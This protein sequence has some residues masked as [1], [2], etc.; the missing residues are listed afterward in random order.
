MK[1]SVVLSLSALVATGC[2]S[3]P[4]RIQPAYVSPLEYS[5]LS[6]EQR[7]EEGAR[8]AERW[9]YLNTKLTHRRDRDVAAVGGALNVAGGA[10]FLMRGKDPALEAEYAQIQGRLVALEDAGKHGC[11]F[12]SPPEREPIIQQS[13]EK[14]W[15]DSADGQPP[16]R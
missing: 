6:C 13:Q 7:N 12:D 4:H 15:L 11:R 8:L 5:A 9:A 3:S 14:P 10:V 2:A 16:P 1:S